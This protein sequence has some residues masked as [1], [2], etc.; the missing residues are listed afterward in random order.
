MDTALDKEK[1]ENAS[2]T[3]AR[4]FGLS[5][6]VLF[7]SQ[8]TGH[9]HRQSDIDI[10]I[11]SEQPLSISELITI[12]DEIERAARAGP[13]EIVDLTHAPPLLLK[14]VAAEGVVLYESNPSEFARFQMYAIKRYIEAKPLFEMR[15]QALDAY[16]QTV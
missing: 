13:V 4:K 5:L 8:A 7:G 6:V 11:Q 12:A 10:A 9:T 16:L 3:V 15:K 1:L 14:A 2:A